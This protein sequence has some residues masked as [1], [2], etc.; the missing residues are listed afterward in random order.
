MQDNR[1]IE[2]APSSSSIVTRNSTDHL[3]NIELIGRVSHQITGVKLPSKK[4]VMQLMFYNMRIVGLRARESARLTIESA[5]IFWQQARIPLQSNFRSV[6]RLIQ[7]YEKWKKI[8]KTPAIRRNDAQ[9]KTINE[10]VDGLDDLF[11]I[12]AD[13]ALETIR[14]DEDKKFL[15]MQR[16]KG[17]PGCMMG[18][19]L[20]LHGR[21]KR[22]QAKQEKEK[23]RKRKHDA[24][25]QN[26]AGNFLNSVISQSN[27]FSVYYEFTASVQL[28]EWSEEEDHTL[29][30][31]L[32]D[33]GNETV[34]FASE[35]N[36]DLPIVEE[37]ESINSMY[38]SKRGRKT[39]ITSRLCSA[40]DNAK[41]SD[42]MAIHILIAAAEALGHRV[43]E[44]AL[45]RSTLRRMREENRMN[46]S[47][48]IQA[49]FT[50]N[51][52]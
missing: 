18:V 27:Y 52:N 23:A 12:A 25:R 11:D 17:R 42:G 51:V 31:E 22:F 4:Q 48:E 5:R 40:L 41:L 2:P 20:I 38:V 45:N 8:R 33:D 49:D 16:E 10:F 26:E 29:L 3:Y 34:N 24:I 39:F 19:D 46:E 43:E 50:D 6:D 28:M 30:D 14:I 9:R 44:L 13:N 35:T 32:T 1:K 47:N 21:E 36:T 15:I 37:V 7:L